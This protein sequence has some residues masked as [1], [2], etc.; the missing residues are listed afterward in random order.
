M[1]ALFGFPSLLAG[2][3][4]LLAGS[5]WFTGASTIGWILI[6]ASGAWIL[7]G[8]LVMIAVFFVTWKAM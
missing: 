6:I 5:T 7:I 8:L 1:L 3:I 2:L 4:L